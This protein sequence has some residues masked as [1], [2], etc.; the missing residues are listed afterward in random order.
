M[1][2]DVSQPRRRH[3]D[4]IY[5]PDLAGKDKSI[6]VF[7]PSYV[8]MPHRLHMPKTYFHKCL[9]VSTVRFLVADTPPEPNNAANGGLWRDHCMPSAREREA[10]QGAQPELP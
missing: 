4:P 9:Q 2:R 5:V 10:P 3:F 6:Q 7:R 1:S 8:Y